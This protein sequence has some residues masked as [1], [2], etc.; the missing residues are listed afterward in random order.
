MECV[1]YYHQKLSSAC[2]LLISSSVC[3]TS[4]AME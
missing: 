3:L 4:A 1:A 2:P